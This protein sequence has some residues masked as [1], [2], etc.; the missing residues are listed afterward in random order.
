MGGNP[1]SRSF[2]ADAAQLEEVR[3]FVSEAAEEAGLPEHAADDLVV[4]VNEAATNSIVH[5]GTT[6]FDVR[7]SALDDRVEVEILDEGMFKRRIRVH[8]LDGV[9][10]LGIPLMM[11]LTDEFE[12]HE[13]TPGRPGTRTRLV[14]FHSTD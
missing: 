11:S 1:I 7:W 4:A 9:G 6:R 3:R 13:G 10:G 5:S 2:V 8:Q 12:L 14:K